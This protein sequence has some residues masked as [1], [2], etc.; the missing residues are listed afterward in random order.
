MLVS[1][2]DQ[3]GGHL[4]LTQEYLLVSARFLG[5]MPL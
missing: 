4:L 1:Q 2:F 3:H 5:L